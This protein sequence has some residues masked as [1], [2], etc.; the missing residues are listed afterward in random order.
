MYI[1]FVIALVAVAVALQVFA[2]FDRVEQF[3]KNDGDDDVGG[4]GDEYHAL[5]VNLD[6]RKDRLKS[7]SDNYSL[8]RPFERIEAIDST[9]MS[10]KEFDMYLSS[11]A[12]EKLNNFMVT[13]KRKSHE[14]LTLGAVGCY[15]SHVKAWERCVELNTPCIIFEDDAKLSPGFETIMQKMRYIVDDAKKPTI[16]LFNVICSSHIWDKLQCKLVENQSNLYKVDVFWSLV[17]YYISVDVA[18]LLLD[19]AFPIEYQVDY[20]ISM[21]A[22]Q[23]IIDVYAY[24][25]LRTADLGSDIQVGDL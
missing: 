13:G 23:G 18:Q 3:D 4:D 11:T 25:V 14:N 19:H 24:P 22:S 2:S 16:L 6:K 17:G 5:V 10:N 21:L 15:L 1:I 9:R 12:R 20:M 8:A 7:F